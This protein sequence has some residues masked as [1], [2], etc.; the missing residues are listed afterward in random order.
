MR[1]S[2]GTKV[3]NNVGFTCQAWLLC[4]TSDLWVQVGHQQHGVDSRRSH[5]QRDARRRHQR[6]GNSGHG[7]TCGHG[8]VSNA[9][10]LFPANPSQS[11]LKT[12]H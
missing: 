3:V 7:E 1:R 12:E 4:V 8:E 10:Q 2:A 6:S 9:F 5:L 11:A